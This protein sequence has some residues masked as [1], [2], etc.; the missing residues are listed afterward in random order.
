MH[1]LGLYSVSYN[2]VRTP[3]N[4]LMAT[5]QAVLF[6]AAARAQDNVQG[7]QKAYVTALSAVLFVLCPL[8][9]GVAAVAS[10]V[11]EGIYGDK[12]AGAESVLFPLALA[13]PVHGAMTGSAL[14][15][16][17][18][19]VATELRVQAGIVVIFIGALLIASQISTQAVAW[20]VFG[21]YLLRA[22]WLTSRILKS[23]HLPWKAF[24]D[25]VRAGV[26]LGIVTAATFY[27]L[28]ARLAFAGLRPFNRLSL[29]AVVGVAI[30]TILPIYVRKLIPSPEFRDVLERAIPT[31]PRLVRAVMQLYAR[32]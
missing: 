8:F 7:H 19:Q 26:L 21:V 1:S 5:V 13:M 28:D 15:W 24:G 2:L 31:S 23:I 10:T 30:V 22:F 14:L 12:W 11:V 3:T 4:H 20:A 6:P 16:A 17:R 29:L 9:F 18:G 27:L 32:T 25:A